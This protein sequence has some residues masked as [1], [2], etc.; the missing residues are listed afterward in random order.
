MNVKK[1]LMYVTTMPHV[2]TLRDF[3]TAPAFMA[4]LE[5]GSIA[6]V[7]ELYWHLRMIL[8]IISLPKELICVK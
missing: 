7:R 2:L 1:E 4:T 3:I 8:L 6:Q 5:T